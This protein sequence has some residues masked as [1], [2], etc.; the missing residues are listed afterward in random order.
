MI[1]VTGATGTTGAAVVHELLQRNAPFRVMARNPAKARDMFGTAVEVVHGDMTDSASLGSAMTGVDTLFLLTPPDERMAA[2]NHQAVV[3]ARS[4][5]VGHVVKLS[6]I[7]A[8]VESPLQLGRWHGAMEQEIA[9]S[10]LGF[11][12][13]RAGSFMQNFFNH[14][15]TILGQGRVFSSNGDGKVAMIDT[16]DIAA[17]AAGILVDP[18]AH[19]GQTY[20]L[21]GG[22]ALSDRDA[23]QLL[24][25]VLERDI[26]FTEISGEAAAAGMKEAGLPAWLIGDLVA[27]GDMA[28]AGYMAHVSARAAELLGRQPRSFEDFAADH[29][30]V[31]SE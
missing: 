24:S 19:A 9:E 2:L 4:A 1:L 15:P 3:A 28:K 8:S 7:G 10:G 13:L 30:D 12:V 18:A 21:T 31:F 17:A 16:R 23:T 25:N 27:L 20:E 26:G 29:A 14:V 22:E 5:G 6:A 11:T